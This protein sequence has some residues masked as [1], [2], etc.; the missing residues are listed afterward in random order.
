MIGSGV[1]RVRLLS[2]VCETLEI[3]LVGL[4]AEKLFG[5]RVGILAVPLLDISQAKIC[6]S[7]EARGYALAAL[8]AT[9]ASYV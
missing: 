9:L 6:E 3:L 1:W 2:V 4:L 5:V 8:L 7:Q